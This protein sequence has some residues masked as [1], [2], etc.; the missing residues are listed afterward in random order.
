MM[1]RF[2]A[3]LGTAAATATL[4]VGLLG[5]AG[6]AEAATTGSWLGCDDGWV[7]VYAEG[8]EPTAGTVTSGYYTYGA[9]NFVNEL[10]FHW[11]TNNQTGGAT[12]T[13]C[14]GYDGTNCT[15]PTIPAGVAINV[16]LTD[17]NSIVLNP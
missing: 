3:M 12:A 15:G 11:V 6:T 7:C 5:T 16:N 8:Q 4:A 10:N 2:K 9:H 1:K 14:Y 17:F 13:L